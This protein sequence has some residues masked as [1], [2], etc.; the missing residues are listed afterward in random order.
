MSAFS[1]ASGQ[2]TESID[3]DRPDQSD[4]VFI[5]KKNKFQIENGIVAGDSTLYN[6]LM[7]RYGLTGS[8]EL[9]LDIAAGKAEG[10]TGLLP[11]SL[12][13]KQ[14]IIN[15]KKIVPAITIIGYIGFEMLA[16]KNFSGRAFPANI[17]LAFENDITGKITLTYNVRTSV[18]FNDL[19]LTTNIGYS[20]QK[21]FSF[22]TEYFADF[23]KNFLPEH[24]IDAGVL[25]LVNNRCQL[26]IAAGH[27]LFSGESRSYLTTG[28]SFRFY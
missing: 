2:T 1:V 22:Y 12:S 13:M 4:G 16:S 8:A 3:T 11:L 27:S 7:L 19:F 23:K 14:R 10:Q 17:E 15:Q 28:I 6:D 20:T 5:L 18:Q 24:N 26:D 9:R 21:R 25:F